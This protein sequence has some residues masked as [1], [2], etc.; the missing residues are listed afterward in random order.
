MARNTRFRRRRTFTDKIQQN[1]R[2]PFVGRKEQIARLRQN[3]QFGPDCNDFLNIFHIYGQGGVG[4][5]TLVQ[6]QYIPMVKAKGYAV[7]LV[8]VED[9]RLREVTATMNDMARQLEKEGGNFGGFFEQYY[10]YLEQKGKLEAD[11]ERP[12]GNLGQLMSENAR[13]GN[14]AGQGATSSQHLS[15][16]HTVDALAKSGGSWADFVARKLGSKAEIDLIL[17]P[18]EILSP[19]WV[20]AFIKLAE[21]RNIAIFLDTYEAANPELNVWWSELLLGRYNDMP[22]NFILF[23]SGREELKSEYWNTFSSYTAKIL[24]KAFTEEEARDYL[25]QRKVTDEAAVEQILSISNLLPVYLSLLAEGDPAHPD[26]IIDPNEKVVERFLR[27]I[28]DPVK[29]GL[30]LQAAIPRQ[31][32]KDVIAC[33][34]PEDTNADKLFEWLTFRP[35]VQKRGGHWTYHPIVRDSMLRYLRERSQKEWRQ[36]HTTLAAFYIREAAHYGALQREEEFQDDNWCEDRVE[37]HYHALCANFRKHLPE[38]V[39][40]FAAVFRLRQCQD[41]LPWAEAIVESEEASGANSEWGCL[42]KTGITAIMGNDLKE[43]LPLFE[44]INESGHIQ[45]LADKA[46]FYFWEAYYAPSDNLEKQIKCYEKTL[47]NKPEDDAAWNN[48]GNAYYDLGDYTKALECY[49]KAIQNKPE[50]NAAWHNMG[51]IYF[52]LGKNIEAVDCYE[53]AINFNPEDD[54]AWYNLGNVHFALGENMKAIHCYQKAIKSQPDSYEAWNNTGNVYDELG[55]IKK[56]IECYQKATEI[57]PERFEAWYNI[58]GAYSVLGDHSKAMDC[59]QRAMESNPDRHE[60]WYNLAGFYDSYNE[61]KLAIQCYQKAVENKPDLYEAWYSMG[62]AYFALAENQKAIECYQKAIES[63]PDGH[64]AWSNMGVVYS[65]LG[66]KQKAINCYQKV[67]YIKPDRYEGWND[68]GGA[69]LAL[70]EKQKAIDFLQIASYIKSDKADSWIN[71]GY[72]YLALGNLEKAEECYQKC[73]E[74]NANDKMVL[75]NYAHLLLAKG[76][77]SEAI[78]YYKKSRDTFQDLDAFLQNLKTDYQHL[79]LSQY[80]ISKENYQKVVGQFREEVPTKY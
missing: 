36:L 14:K 28:N 19:L 61:K 21:T 39:R 22:L 6:R 41:S 73:F 7:A 1:D 51:L 38:V 69:Y 3:L 9:F 5:T 57:L 53:N 58:G 70:G 4:K 20:E 33:L 44:K 42:I 59:Y 15:P 63:K 79:N 80:N 35:F 48:M 45:H 60:V 11:P 13:W 52:A 31:L 12:K 68:I 77:F 18:V 56:A 2:H 37:M 65:S 76:N 34:I 72:A 55:Q 64:E 40:D 26:D 50:Y 23:I 43:A 75:L 29:R 62:D 46:D 47:E 27:H 66:D 10:R 8:D 49:E 67:I 74:I 25:K 78:H 54:A 32:N 16:E 71:L 30:A 24:V 17:H